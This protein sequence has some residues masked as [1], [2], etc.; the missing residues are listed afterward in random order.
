MH[1]FNLQISC[2]SERNPFAGSFYTIVFNSDQFPM[3][4]HL[5]EDN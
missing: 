4:A 5:A 2:G 3:D 1:N